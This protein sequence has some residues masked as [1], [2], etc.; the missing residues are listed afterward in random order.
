VEAALEGMER[1]D[2]DRLRTILHPYIR[3]TLADGSL[4][5]GRLK[6]LAMLAASSAQAAPSA[7]ELRDGQIYRWTEPGSRVGR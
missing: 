1:Q 5:R 3:W 2:R 7:P 6:V 4:M